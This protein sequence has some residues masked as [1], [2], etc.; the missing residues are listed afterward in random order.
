MS[1]IESCKAVMSLFKQRGWSA[2][3]N[4]DLV[5]NVLFMFSFV[6]GMLIGGI[7]AIIGTT[8]F[9]ELKDGVVVVAIAGILIGVGKDIEKL[10]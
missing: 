8:G 2:I 6:I 4:D 10:S 5:G 7:G 3:V 1:Y 9:I